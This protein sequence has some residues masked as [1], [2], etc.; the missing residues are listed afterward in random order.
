MQA[1]LTLHLR[2]VAQH[3]VAVYDWQGQFPVNPHSSFS[4]ISLVLRQSCGAV[5]L[6]LSLIQ[7]ISS[8]FL[9]RWICLSWCGDEWQEGWANVLWAHWTWQG[10][11]WPGSL[12]QART[13]PRLWPPTDVQVYFHIS[14]ASSSVGWPVSNRPQHQFD[15]CF[16][17]ESNSISVFQGPWIQQI[18]CTASPPSIWKGYV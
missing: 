12:P 5:S 10:E 7:R 13:S 2:L 18:V 3:W 11:V 9:L 14:T 4:L 17:R 8:S 15:I 16:D 6:S 1:G